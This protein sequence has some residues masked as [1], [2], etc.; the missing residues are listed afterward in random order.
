MIG[1]RL[2]LKMEDNE[3]DG[4]WIF[5]WEPVSKEERKYTLGKV[6]EILVST[7]FAKHIYLY[8]NE[9]YK[10]LK[11]GAI[12]LRPTGIV[13]RIVIDRL[14]KIFLERLSQA[15]IQVYILKK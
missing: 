3:P 5:L 14:T 13:A 2:D 4:N 11:G 12:G 15:D 1:R 7:I 8:K 9:L 6:L 10:Q